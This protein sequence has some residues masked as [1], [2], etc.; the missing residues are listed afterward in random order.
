MH[1][2][3]PF[4]DRRQRRDASAR[5]RTDR[6][7]HAGEKDFYTASPADQQELRTVLNYGRR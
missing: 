4:A 5:R 6:C 2:D 3:L 7:V 1:H